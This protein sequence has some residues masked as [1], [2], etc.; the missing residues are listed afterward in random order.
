MLLTMG[1][2]ARTAHPIGMS[3]LRWSQG[4]VVIPA[5]QRG[6]GRGGE[7]GAGLAGHP[8]QRAR[9]RRAHVMGMAA[10]MMVRIPLVGIGRDL[11]GIAIDMRPGRIL[12]GF[13]APAD[14]SRMRHP[15]P[16][17]QDEHQTGEEG[18]QPTHGASG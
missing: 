6:I 17:G 10:A 3:G 8:G 13:D 5:D 16:G 15:D 14:L 11:I 7:R 12:P 2:R 18:Q 1:T 9:I 4:S